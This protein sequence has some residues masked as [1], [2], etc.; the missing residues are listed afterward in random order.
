[1]SYH[2]RRTSF[3]LNLEEIEKFVWK[4]RRNTSSGAAICYFSA[5]FCCLCIAAS[6]L[7]YAVH[8]DTIYI[9]AGERRY[10]NPLHRTET[11]RV[12]SFLIEQELFDDLRDSETTCFCHLECHRTANSVDGLRLSGSDKVDLNRKSDQFHQQLVPKMTSPSM[13]TNNFLGVMG[14]RIS[15]SC[16]RIYVKNKCSTNSWRHVAT[17]NYEFCFIV[18]KANVEC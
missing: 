15:I 6:L 18:T 11:L 16:S 9:S 12:A 14:N 7:S 1:M 13:T 3:S 8:V 10:P 5:A 4:T 17:Y 2:H